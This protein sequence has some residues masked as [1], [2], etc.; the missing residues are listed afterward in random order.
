MITL[1]DRPPVK[2]ATIEALDEAFER[3]QREW[4]WA[5]VPEYQGKHG[6][7]F[8]AGRELIEAFLKAPA[9]SSARDIEH[10]HSDKIVYVALDDPLISLNVDTPEEYAALAPQM[11]HSK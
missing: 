8:L 1:V 2:P 7:P 3:A 10:A 5:V 9:S 6:H 11:V 4:K